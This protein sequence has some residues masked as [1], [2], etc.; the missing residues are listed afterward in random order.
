MLPGSSLFP[1]SYQRYLNGNVDFSR[2]TEFQTNRFPST[3]YP[4]GM[5]LP[6][7][8]TRISR[9]PPPKQIPWQQVYPRFPAAAVLK[10]PQQHPVT[11]Y[12]SST[13]CLYPSQQSIPLSNAVS[14]PPEDRQASATE[15]KSFADDFPFLHSVAKDL[16]HIFGNLDEEKGQERPL[17]P[18]LEPLTELESI[19]DSN[20]LASDQTDETSSQSSLTSEEPAN[21]EYVQSRTYNSCCFGNDSDFSRGFVSNGRTF[22]F[23]RQD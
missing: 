17:T 3:P 18:S 11:H 23:F 10:V 15:T 16:P 7:A 1:S 19:C 21:G 12:Q 22:R 8:S 4:V 9:L 5:P 2:S 6:P 14:N 13:A 20:S